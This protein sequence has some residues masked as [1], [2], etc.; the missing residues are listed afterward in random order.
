MEFLDKNGSTTAVH[1]MAKV[2]AKKKY[3][4]DI[5]TMTLLIISDIESIS[6]YT[7]YHQT[8]ECFPKPTQIWPRQRFSISRFLFQVG[9]HQ[10]HWI[11]GQLSLR[12][13]HRFASEIGRGRKHLN[14]D[15]PLNFQL[16]DGVSTVWGLDVFSAN[17]VIRESRVLT[18][19]TFR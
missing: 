6:T 18:C 15:A 19:T 9:F 17:N 1:P 13:L 14:V 8:Y 10:D 5:I 11:H 7:L 2:T 16:M 12:R 4:I 3:Y